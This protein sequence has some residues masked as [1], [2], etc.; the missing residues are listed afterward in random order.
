MWRCAVHAHAQVVAQVARRA[1]CCL[2]AH[3]ARDHPWRRT[4]RTQVITPSASNVT[5]FGSIDLVMRNPPTSNNTVLSISNARLQA[6]IGKALSVSTTQVGRAGPGGVG[7]RTTSRVAAATILC[8]EQ[9]L[10]LGVTGRGPCASALM[11]HS[12]DGKGVSGGA[13]MWRAC[14]GMGGRGR[15]CQLAPTRITNNACGSSSQSLRQTSPSYNTAM[16]AVRCVL[17]DVLVVVA[18]PPPRAQV[19][20]VVPGTITLTPVA[21]VKDCPSPQLGV[22]CGADAV[23]AIVGIILGG[24][25]VIGLIIWAW[26][27]TRRGQ[28]GGDQWGRGRVR[29]G[30]DRLGRGG[31]GLAKWRLCCPCRIGLRLC[32]ACVACASSVGRTSTMHR[33]QRPFSLLPPPPP[34]PAQARTRPDPCLR[35]SVS[36][37]HPPTP[38]NPATAPG[39]TMP[40]PPPSHP[41]PQETKVMVMDDMTWAKKYSHIV[42]TN[43]IASPYVTQYGPDAVV[44]NNAAYS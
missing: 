29:G 26:I 38:A 7:T 16:H 40:H 22:L 34:F 36:Y 31:E 9:G 12:N 15:G 32:A 5:Q 11:I 23:G 42:P 28:V 6:S 17:I 21:S 27:Y 24:L 13:G 25:I 10:H 1:N 20:M 30:G 37:E 2:P 14:A 35:S 18:V 8:T 4:L 41:H 39:P 44:H 33:T 19:V 43:V 3:V